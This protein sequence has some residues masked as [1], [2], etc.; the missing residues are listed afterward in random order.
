MEVVSSELFVRVN[1]VRTLII[2]HVQ[3]SHLANMQAILDVNQVNGVL[4]PPVM[5]VLNYEHYGISLSI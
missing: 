5:S 3:Q 2:D 1:G 4:T